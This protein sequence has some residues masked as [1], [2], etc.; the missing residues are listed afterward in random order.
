MIDL[1][2]VIEG[3]EAL[4][5][6][7]LMWIL[8]VPKTL[9]KI[10]FHP[11]WAPG[12]VAEQLKGDAASR[13]DD[14]LSPVILIILSTLIP[15]AYAYITPKPGV[16]L[17]GPAQS[18]INQVA[19]FT[20]TANF[21]SRDGRYTY[22][23]GEWVGDKYTSYGSWTSDQV[24]DYISNNWDSSGWK[25]V[26]VTASNDKGESYYDEY[27]IYI[28]DP[29]QPASEQGESVGATP[30]ANREA[31]T[32]RSVLE[33]TPG[34]LAALAFLSIPLL[35]ALAIEAFRGNSLTPSSL[36][37]S[38]YVQCY[39]LAPFA[40]A[41]W[42]LILGVEYFLTPSEVPLIAL[43][44]L[45]V[46]VLFIQLF[47]NEV[48]L[49]AAER[50][51]NRG[52]AFWIVLGCLVLIMIVAGIIVFLRRDAEA[53]RQFLGWFYV[54][55][56]TVLFLTGIWRGIFRKRSLNNAKKTK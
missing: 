24:T 9:A 39:F 3:I 2:K 53:F 19:N 4:A 15:F 7:M 51:L 18:K 36:M 17:S 11:A 10:V 45:V 48:L 40:L 23:W 50:R 14:Y 42:A 30:S 41:S 55:F 47:R 46:L 32:W 13:F 35:F 21:I 1:T 8:L 37:R 29:S 12:Y 31:G 27:D 28:I 22:E 34:F 43:A 44:G 49:I 52:R 16:M 6:E 54:A 56:V 38:F 5:Y 26:T 20:A 33:G 25:T